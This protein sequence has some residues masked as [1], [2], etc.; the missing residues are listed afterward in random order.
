M[1]KISIQLTVICLIALGVAISV[2]GQTPSQPTDRSSVQPLATPTPRA[3]TSA[4][5]GPLSDPETLGKILAKLAFETLRADSKTAEVEDL[6]KNRDEWKAAASLE[7]ARGDE[8]QKAERARAEEAASLRVAEGFLRQSV[9][10]Y[11]QET[12]D[13]RREVDRLRGSRKWYAGAG[14]VGGII[15]CY[16]VK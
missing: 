10:E 15:A 4:V 2:S 14:F 16:G 13:L 9:T 8:L 12:A 1:K 7:K 6:K 5:P 11:K 3:E